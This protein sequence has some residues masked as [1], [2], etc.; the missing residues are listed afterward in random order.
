M[1]VKVE[2]QDNN[3]ALLTIEIDADTL[4]QAIDK[5][6]RASRGRINVPGFRKGKAPR[7][8]IE[9]LYGAGI[10][11]EDAA[12]DVIDSTYSDAAEDSGE[13]IV[14]MPEIAVVQV[15][16]GKPFIYTAKVALRP[17]VKLGKYKGIKVSKIDDTVSDEELTAEIERVRGMNARSV[18]VTDRPVKDGDTVTL[19]FEGFID[20][21]AFEGGK[22]ENYPLTIGSGSF[23]PG[24]EEKLIGAEID[25]ELD[26][27][28]TFPEDY[29]EES[30]RSKEAVFK[31][32]VHGIREKELP[33]LNDDYASDVSE[34]ET[35]AEYQEDVK[36]KL[37]EKKHADAEKERED[38]VI[39]E[40]VADSELELPEA[41]VESNIDMTMRNY[42][43]Q[44]RM[45]GLSLEQY[46]Q[47]T[48]QT[49]EAMRDQMKPSVEKRLKGA[50]VL[51]EIARKEDLRVSDEEL[52]EI[53]Q[54]QA[55]DYKMSLDELKKLL[56]RAQIR[57]IRENSEIEK[58]TKFV[59]EQVKEK[60]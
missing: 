10:F 32:T 5:A 12:N 36:K 52:E 4:E 57:E 53:L 35:F 56:S 29:H 47:Y 1:S 16:S 46:I 2:K 59:M 3:M 49:V 33:E 30:L 42:A 24:F 11:Y 25:K 6:Y 45:Q 41:M 21:E 37:S 51:E 28:V 43:Q 7:K 22:G 44:L 48:G 50:L 20:G 38:Q 17:P 27:E 9:K 31:C 8:M 55:D 39:D 18:D 14:S 60:K 13:E 15:E 23:I 19:D 40:I 26:V 58:A 54:K 34:F